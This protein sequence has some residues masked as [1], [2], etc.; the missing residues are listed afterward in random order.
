MDAVLGHYASQNWKAF[1]K[2]IKHTVALVESRPDERDEKSKRAI[3]PKLR[4]Q[5]RKLGGIVSKFEMQEDRVK[6]NFAFSFVEGESKYYTDS[7]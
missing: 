5:W 6:N 4:E 2:V 1:L 7:N 3:S